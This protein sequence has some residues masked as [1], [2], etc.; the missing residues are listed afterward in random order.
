MALTNQPGSPI[1]VGVIAGARVAVPGPLVLA[2]DPR[3]KPGP[4]PPCHG[5]MDSTNTVDKRSGKLQEGVILVESKGT[6][7]VRQYEWYLR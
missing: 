1:L 3:H 2:G 5:E 7:Y 6:C 4:P